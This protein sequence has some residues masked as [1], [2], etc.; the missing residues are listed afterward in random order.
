MRKKIHIFRNSSCE[1]LCNICLA[2]FGRSAELKSDV[3]DNTDNFMLEVC[4]YLKGKFLS[5]P[6][7][8]NS[9]KII[10]H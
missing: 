7:R 2:F 5:R 3:T 4:S 8:K 1:R 10:Y 9:D 6:V